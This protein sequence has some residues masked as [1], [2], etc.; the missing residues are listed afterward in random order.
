MVL[1]FFE[2]RSHWSVFHCWYPRLIK[3]IHTDR[4]CIFWTKINNP[5]TVTIKIILYNTRKIAV[6]NS[7]LILGGAHNALSSLQMVKNLF[8]ACSCKAGVG[9][10]ANFFRGLYFYK[11]LEVCKISMEACSLWLCT[12]LYD[13]LGSSLEFCISEILHRSLH[14]YKPL[15]RCVKL[16][17]GLEPLQRSALI[18]NLKGWTKSTEL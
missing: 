8:V 13:H 17:G 6:E 7:K 18:E 9:Y 2:L 1:S 4:P 11:P 5:L 12:P 10:S 15:Q 16:C 3:E 14:L